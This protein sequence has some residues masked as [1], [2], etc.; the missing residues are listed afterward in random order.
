MSEPADP[1]AAEAARAV[2]QKAYK[3]LKKKRAKQK[4][5]EQQQEQ[6]PA[7]GSENGTDPQQAE[8]TSAHSA[9]VS[10]KTWCRTFAPKKST[11]RSVDD[12]KVNDLL[13][14]RS[15]AKAEM[16]YAASDAITRALAELEVVY[17]DATR[18]WHTR[19]L[20]TDAQKQA[21]AFKKRVRES[22][23]IDD[24]KKPRKKIRT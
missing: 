22:A 13:K 11:G 20:L 9:L 5:R 23:M 10:G 1:S 17:D 4:K 15:A 7:V 8:S 14:K 18:E 19:E 16:D 12:D 3:K 2:A 24:P 6:Q 21:R